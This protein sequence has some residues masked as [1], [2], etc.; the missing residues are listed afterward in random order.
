M[1]N[2]LHF[3]YSCADEET[4]QGVGTRGVPGVKDAGDVGVVSIV[5]L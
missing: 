3:L 2:R 1:M 4:K 5:D